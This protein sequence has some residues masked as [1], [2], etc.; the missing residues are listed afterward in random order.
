[1]TT[2]PCQLPADSCRSAGSQGLVQT[3][4]GTWVSCRFSVGFWSRCVESP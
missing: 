1:V 2:T 3:A 4:R